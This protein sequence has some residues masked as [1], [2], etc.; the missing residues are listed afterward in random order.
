MRKRPL[1]DEE[2]ALWETEMQAAKPL[3]AAERVPKKT[4][5]K[6]IIVKPQ[7]LLPQLPTTNS[8]FPLAI[9][10]Y[11][12]VDKNTAE[13]FR[14]GERPID[15]TLDLHGMTKEAAHR[16]LTRFIHQEIRRESRNLLVITGKG[17][18]NA[19]QSDGS[20][21]ILRSSLPAWL[22]EPALRGFILALEVAK[23]RHGGTGAY[24]ILL[25]RKR[26]IHDDR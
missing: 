10:E 16:S 22:A 2:K 21:G 13:R 23:P 15:A 26:E 4:P 3:P 25:K 11:A 5:T 9:G 8:Q 20:H 12:G 17:Q 6:K 7:H 18:K 19:V 14:K 1:T 24:Y